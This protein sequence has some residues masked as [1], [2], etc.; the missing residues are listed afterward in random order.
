MSDHSAAH[1]R[2][3]RDFHLRQFENP[4]PAGA[5]RQAWQAGFTEAA[6]RYS[7]TVR[8]RQQYHFEQQQ[9]VR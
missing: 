4:Y 1:R 8:A 7:A 2:G 6:Q 3:S 9:A 5:A